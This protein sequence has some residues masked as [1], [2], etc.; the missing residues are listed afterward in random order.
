MRTEDAPTSIASV[1]VP[2]FDLSGMQCKGRVVDVHDGDTI[3]MVMESCGRVFSC[4]CRLFGIDTPEMA[5]ILK[6]RNRVQEIR[7][8]KLAR[9]A[10]ISLVTDIELPEDAQECANISCRTNTRLVDV[11]CRGADKY[12]RQLVN[13]R[14]AGDIDVTAK[15]IECGHG[16]AYDGGHKGP[17]VQIS[18][19]RKPDGSSGSNKSKHSA[20]LESV[21]VQ[22]KKNVHESRDDV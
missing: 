16:V 8:A 11:T 17:P 13:L 6:K 12:G 18:R 1:D 22:H 4:K 20:K 3:T 15:L 19:K 9:N 14:V 10:L 7:R 21:P 2:L 5:P